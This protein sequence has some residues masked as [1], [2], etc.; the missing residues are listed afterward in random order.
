MMND[1]AHISLEDLALHATQSL[2]ANESEAVRSHLAVCALCRSDL[3]LV[4]GD[5]A[6]LGLGAEEKPLPEGAR[7]RFLDKLAAAPAAS[8]LKQDPL[9]P[10]NNP[11]VVTQMIPV[12]RRRG[13]AFWTPWLVAAA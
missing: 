12:P 10:R 7:Q 11:S 4:T 3:S 1:S 13:A 9:H 5:L 8:P 6:A 2:S